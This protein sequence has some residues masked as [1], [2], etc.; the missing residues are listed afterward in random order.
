MKTSAHLV[1]GNLILDDEMRESFLYE[2]KKIKREIEIIEDRNWLKKL[3]SFILAYKEVV[4]VLNIHCQFFIGSEGVL[5]Y[6]EVLW[7]WTNATLAE[8]L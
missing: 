5:F 4:N 2:L 7:R 1:S 3:N 8:L 6:W